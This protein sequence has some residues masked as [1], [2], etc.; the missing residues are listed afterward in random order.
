[1]IGEGA[2][3]AVA[4]GMAALP[5]LRERLR[6][7]MDTEARRAAPGSFADLPQGRTHYT[8]LG[9]SRGPVAVCIHGLSTPSFVYRG[10]A[11]QLAALGFKVLLYD[12]YGRGFSD[13][14]KGAQS[15][16]FFVTQLRDLLRHLEVT[17]EVTLFGYSMG[18]VIAAA[19]GAH[20]AHQLRRI[21]LLAPAGMGH[22]LG[23]VARFATGWPLLGDWVFHMGY[24]MQ[25]ARGLRAEAETPKSIERFEDMA[26]AELRYRGYLPALLSS[27]RHTLKGPIPAIH[28][29]LADTGVPVAAIWG[30]DDTV[31]PISGLGTLA[32][33]NRRAQ[34]EVIEGAGHGLIYTHTEQVGAAVRKLTGLG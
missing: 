27:L 28:K 31:I 6:A 24:P 21:V 4:A 17:E 5:A 32:Q 18:G 13:R 11:R 25:L 26:Q 9:A 33:W 15:P 3:L 30:R 8:W 1:M 29:Q 34:Q 16:A 7:P 10:L 2:S 23:R 22:E 20:H 12:L 19:Y 14:P